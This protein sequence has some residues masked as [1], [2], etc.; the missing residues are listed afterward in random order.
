MIVDFNL[1]ILSLFE[2]YF[3]LCQHATGSKTN[4]FYSQRHF[5]FAYISEAFARNQAD[6]KVTSTCFVSNIEKNQRFFQPSLDDKV[7]RLYMKTLNI[8]SY[9]KLIA[10]LKSPSFKPLAVQQMEQGFYHDQFP[11]VQLFS[12]SL[13]HPR[14]LD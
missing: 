8:T 6:Q 14:T 13:L 5:V 12:G 9:S 3:L 10:L 2:F 11:K 1:L 7:Y 4:L